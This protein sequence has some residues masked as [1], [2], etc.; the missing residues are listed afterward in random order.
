MKK[1]GMDMGNSFLDT[2]VLVT[3]GTSGIGKAVALAFGRRGSRVIICGRDGEAGDSVTKEIRQRNGKSEFIQADLSDP[4]QV[5]SLFSFIQ[6]KYQRLDCVFNGAGAEAEV[7]PLAMQTEKHFDEMVS[8]DLKGTWLCMK[9]EI[10]LMRNQGA[11]TIVNC[12]AMA[13]LRGARG[14]SIY[15][16]CKHGIIGLTK[17]AAL[18]YAEHNIRINAICPGMV[19]TPGLERVFHK[20]PGF[21]YEEVIQWGISQIPMNRFGR[22]EEVAEAVL[23]LCSDESSYLTGHSLIIDGGIQCR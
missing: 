19:Q 1:G 16:A 4:E 15:S 12:S 21:R 11:G 6:Q 3:G 20:I 23:W 9:H 5:D 7:A 18:E 10:Q 22:A 14:S 2:I 13:G 17:S 8:V